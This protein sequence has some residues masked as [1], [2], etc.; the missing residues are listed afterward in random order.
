MT[1][2]A[3]NDIECISCILLSL[4]YL[5]T[6]STPYLIFVLEFPR[7]KRTCTKTVFVFT[8][9]AETMRGKH[10][11]QSNQLVI[12]VRI[13]VL[14]HRRQFINHFFVPAAESVFHLRATATLLVQASA[15]VE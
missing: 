3:V 8:W 4:F 1:T 9:S 6:L 5:N 14:V 11:A 7:E 13:L 15:W 10:L 2:R 12:L